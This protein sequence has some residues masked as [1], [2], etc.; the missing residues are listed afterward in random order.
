MRQ[1]DRENEREREERGKVLRERVGE[2]EIHIKV[3]FEGLQEILYRNDRRER[4]SRMK[5]NKK[6]INHE[7][8]Q[9][10]QERDSMNVSNDEKKDYN[11]EAT[12]LLIFYIFLCNFTTHAII[13]Y[14]NYYY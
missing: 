3:I 2:S 14:Y 5:G 9:C 8:S 6:K 10:E 7:T 12:S 4:K 13:Y 1:E 11:R